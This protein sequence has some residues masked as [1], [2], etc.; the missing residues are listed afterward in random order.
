M[1][2]PSTGEVPLALY[3][4]GSVVSADGTTIGYRKLG[5][6]PALVLVHGGMMAAQGFMQ[7][8]SALAD[9]FTLY[10]P[11]RRGRGLSGPHGAHYAMA[12]EV[13]DMQALI[14][15]A[16][17]SLI[18]GLSSGALVTMQTALQ[19][20]SLRKVALYEPP[21]SL[22]GPDSIRG[23]VPP[24]QK[25]LAE[26]NLAGAMVTVLKGTD[27]SLF[28]K[29]PRFITERLIGQ[30]VKARPGDT[31]SD[32]VPLRM[33]IPTMEYDQRLVKEM[34]GSLER[35]KTLEAE[36]LLLGG[37]KSIGYLKT[38]LDALEMT[39]PH[40]RRVTLQGV[41]HIAATDDEQPELVAGELRK[42]FA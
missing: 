42:F 15:A 11:D 23:W 30:A 25:N 26:G 35:F 36:V 37:T 20:P 39:I 5:A 28:A 24:Y 29:L 3:T 9:A 32:H 12:R 17:A 6:G 27:T 7:L 22:K 14:A 33:L 16:E 13:E 38:A 41:G 40:V 1:T 4:K 21:L 10:V 8:A 34:D 2:S 18:F 31:D 19:T